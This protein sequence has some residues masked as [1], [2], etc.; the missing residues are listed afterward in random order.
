[1][2]DP[3]EDKSTAKV[4]VGRRPVS[5]PALAL[6]TINCRVPVELAQAVRDEAAKHGMP[7]AEAVRELLAAGLAA[8][9]KE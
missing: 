3:Q 4:P 2:V 6:A 1:M 5:A 9:E 8:R 7:I